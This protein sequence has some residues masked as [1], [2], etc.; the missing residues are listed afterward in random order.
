MWPAR[1]HLI[2]LAEWNKDKVGEQVKISHSS[3]S[4][5]TFWGDFEGFVVGI[6]PG[7]LKVHVQCVLDTGQTFLGFLDDLFLTKRGPNFLELHF[8]VENEY[9]YKIEC[10]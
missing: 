9:I 3:K 8:K 1:V 6:N 2:P 5:M 7:S 10:V 4:N